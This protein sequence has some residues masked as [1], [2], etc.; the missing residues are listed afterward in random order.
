MPLRG[1]GPDPDDALDG[2]ITVV[3]MWTVSW[4]FC[5]AWSA[6]LDWVEGPIRGMLRSPQL[7]VRHRQVKRARYT[8]SDP[9]A[10][11][12]GKAAAPAALVGVPG[13]TGDLGAAPT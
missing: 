1:L 2:K 12:P 5:N 13:D 7:A 6:W 10:G 8:S 11:L 4:L 9:C 3:V